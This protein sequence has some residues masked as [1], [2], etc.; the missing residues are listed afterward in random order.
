MSFGYNVLGFGSHPSRGVPLAVEWLLIAGGGASHTGGPSGGGGGGGYLTAVTDGITPATSFFPG[1]AYTV[2]VGAGGA[3][4]GNPGVDSSVSG[5][6]LTTILSIGGGRGGAGLSF[7]PSIGGSGGGGAG[8]QSGGYPY[9]QAGAIGTVGPPRQ[10]YTGGAGYMVSGYNSYIGGG[11]G[12]AGG[13]G[14][15][16]VNQYFSSTGGGGRSGNVDTVA[17]GGGGG[18]SGNDGWRGGVGSSGGGSGNSY[19]YN[20]GNQAGYAN[21][22]GGGG[23]GAQYAYAP[24]NRPAPGGSGIAIFKYEGGTRATGGTITFVSG[25]TLHTFNSSGTFTPL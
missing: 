19:Y 24:P 18:G 7:F 2:T 17:R 3:N 11:G 6:G 21:T 22:G 25:Y 9:P 10:G 1:I 16:A 20:R 23:G 4:G 15:G 8:A 13:N 5:A 12:G 14:T